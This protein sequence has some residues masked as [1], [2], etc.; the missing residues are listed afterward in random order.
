[1]TL[2]TQQEQTEMDH[3]IRD[4][5]QRKDHQYPELGLRDTKRY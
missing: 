4:F 3:K 5:L 1:M 2:F